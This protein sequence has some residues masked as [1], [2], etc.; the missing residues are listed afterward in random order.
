MRL[1]V[2]G[3]AGRTGRLIVGKA[4]GHGHEVTAFTHEPPPGPDHPRLKV[5][6]GDV[7]DASSV[8]AAMGGHDAVAFALST[9]SSGTGVHEAGIAN[10][11]Y[12]MAENQVPRLAAVS[13]AGTFDRTNSRLSLA[14]RALI[15]TVLRTTYDDLEAMERRIMATDL[16][17]TIVRPMGLSD[18]P[19]TG[20]YRVSRDGALLPKGRRVSRGDVA[21][22]VVKALETDTYWRRTV[23]I[24]R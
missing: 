20:D 18:D 3:A 6:A 10:V 22:L 8:R 7:R 24:S 14:R 12:A 11:I 13:A 19:P 9:A 16:A 2:F 4:L 1:L 5:A 15:A 17:W 23:V 21:S